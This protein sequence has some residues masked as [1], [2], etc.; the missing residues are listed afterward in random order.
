MKTL[1]IITA[2]IVGGYYFAP[3]KTQD[4]INWTG[5]ASVKIVSKGGSKLAEFV[6][7]VWK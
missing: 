7:E 2:I 6:K 5:S 1:L 3:N 4:A